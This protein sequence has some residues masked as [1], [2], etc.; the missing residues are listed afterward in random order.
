MTSGAHLGAVPLVEIT[1]RDVRAIDGHSG[2]EEIVESVHVGHLV[3]VD[4][5]GATTHEAGNAELVIFPRSALKP[6]QATLCLE[7]LDRAGVQ[8]SSAETAIGWA[9]HR[10]EPAQLTAVRDLLARGAIAEATLSCPRASVPDEPSATRSRIAHN[11]SGKHALF[12]VTAHA[13]GLPG[14]P[15]SLLAHDGPLQ[16][17]LLAGLEELLGPARA[18]GVDGCG[19]PALAVPLVAVAR[20]FARLAAEDRFARVRNAGLAHPGLI[21]GYERGPG[22]TLRPLVDS[23]LLGA[24]VVAKRGAEGVIAVGWCTADGTAGGITAKASDGSLRGVATAVVAHLEATG[25][26]PQGTWREPAPQGGGLDAGLVR[27]AHRDRS[28]DQGPSAAGQSS[29]RH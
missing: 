7:L 27:A 24:G 19:A 21:G 25:V 28:G 26:V 23:A 1:R 10:A 5:E 16:T 2:S 22:G 12:A 13:L 8:L 15:A 4:G 14:D 20:A 9:S 11:C 17:L 3:A 6:L 29:E 18:V